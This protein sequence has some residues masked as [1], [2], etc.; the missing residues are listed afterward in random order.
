MM[1]VLAMFDR[2]FIFR[3]DTKRIQASSPIEFEQKWIWIEA[4]NEGEWNFA[5]SVRKVS[6]GK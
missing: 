4:W 2:E 1:T 6:S 3:T 5:A